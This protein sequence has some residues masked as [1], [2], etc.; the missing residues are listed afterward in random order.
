MLGDGQHAFGC[1]GAEEPTAE[2]RKGVAA[3]AL[4]HQDHRAAAQLRE[5]LHRRQV[6]GLPWATWRRRRRRAACL[7]VELAPQVARLVEVR[8]RAKEARKLW[9]VAHAAREI[10]VDGR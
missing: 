3:D 1:S 2:K 6:R 7:H 4:A 9:V 8:A 10:L 5:K